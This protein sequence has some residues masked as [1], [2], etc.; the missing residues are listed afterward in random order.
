MEP[1][2]DEDVSDFG[3]EPDLP[4]GADGDRV[5]IVKPP[6]PVQA[7][8]EEHDDDDEDDTDRYISVQFAVYELKQFH[9][10][11]NIC[12]N[13][14]RNAP[15]VSLTISFYYSQTTNCDLKDDL[16]II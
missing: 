9:F 3:D 8:V 10:F 14:K 11:R 12:L 16:N 7:V 5:D 1:V 4:S 6:S 13:S 15:F 2:S